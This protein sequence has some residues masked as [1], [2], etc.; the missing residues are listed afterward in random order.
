MWIF[1]YFATKFRDFSKT[2]ASD[3]AFQ[4]KT[5]IWFLECKSHLLS[6]DVLSQHENKSKQHY[7]PVTDSTIVQCAHFSGRFHS[8]CPLHPSHP[9]LPHKD[10]KAKGMQLKRQ[11]VKQSISLSETVLSSKFILVRAFV[12][13][14]RKLCLMIASI[15]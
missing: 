14:D 12:S 3:T 10:M 5:S 11:M 4:L 2:H 15:F 7:L 6:W 9:T 8:T 13:V 1:K